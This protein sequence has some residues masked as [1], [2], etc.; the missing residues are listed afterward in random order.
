MITKAVKQN[1]HCYTLNKKHSFHVHSVYSWLIGPQP[2]TI[3]R[4]RVF[5][6]MLSVV[7]CEK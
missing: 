5:N 1:G 6:Y 4:Q 2:P 3:P 7:K